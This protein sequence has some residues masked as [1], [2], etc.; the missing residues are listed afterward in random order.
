MAQGSQ[1]AELEYF[2]LASGHL[3]MLG[4]LDAVKQEKPM[5]ENC[6]SFSAL[7]PLLPPLRLPQ[8]LQQP[9][10]QLHLLLQLFHWGIPGL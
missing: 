9:P 8:L 6:R 2:G 3:Q 10:H 7:P 5:V 4:V 1:T